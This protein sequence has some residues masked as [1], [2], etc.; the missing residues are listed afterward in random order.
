MVEGLIY[1]EGTIPSGAGFDPRSATAN[2]TW[3]CRGWLIFS[4]ARGE[5]HAI[6]HQEYLLGAELSS[7]SPSPPDQLTSSGTEAVSR[8][9]SAP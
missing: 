3:L 2:G 6:T 8:P 1:P 4:A 5:P 7:A 9:A